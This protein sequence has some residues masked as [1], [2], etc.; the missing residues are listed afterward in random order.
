MVEVIKKAGERIYAPIKRYDKA[1]KKQTN[2]KRYDYIGHIGMGAIYSGIAGTLIGYTVSSALQGKLDASAW[3]LLL[4]LD[5]L[6]AA[7]GAAEFTKA[8]ML[9]NKWLKELETANK[10]VKELSDEL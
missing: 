2:E 7:G 8:G 5:S 10:K 3:C 1:Y 6:L 4:S 9:V